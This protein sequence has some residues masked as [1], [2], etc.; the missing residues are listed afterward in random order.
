MQVPF[1]NFAARL[2][3]DGFLA[4]GGTTGFGYKTGKGVGGTVTQITDRSTGV[5]INKLSGTI[6]TDAT[7]LATGA[8]ATFVVTNS[9]VA[10]TDVVV[11]SL[12][13][14]TTTPGSTLVSVTAVAAGSFSITL[15]NLHASVADT[16]AAV[17][18][19]AVIKS[20]AN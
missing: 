19:F 3:A 4:V 18:N 1:R 16:A 2:K 9:K 5:T 10:A 12:K 17:I 11:V 13:S 6:T 7:S 14:G 15:A 20:T 8:E